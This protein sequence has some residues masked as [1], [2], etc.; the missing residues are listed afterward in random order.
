MKK[1]LIILSLVTLT[2][3]NAQAQAGDCAGSVHSACDTL[4]PQ[5]NTSVE[6]DKNYGTCLT[7]GVKLLCRT[8]TQNTISLGQLKKEVL[9]KRARQASR[10]AS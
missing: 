8:N 7:V 3:I 5:D 2:G 10:S 6:D 1:A 9:K 4:F